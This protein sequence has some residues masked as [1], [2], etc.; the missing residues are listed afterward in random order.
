MSVHL[1]IFELTSVDGSVLESHF[2]VV[3]HVVEPLPGED[4]AVAPQHCAFSFTFSG[5]EESFILGFFKFH[6]A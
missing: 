1:I 3:S 5:S 2:S 6:P 4:G